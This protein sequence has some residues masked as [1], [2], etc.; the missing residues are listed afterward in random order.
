VALSATLPAPESTAARYFPVDQVMQIAGQRL[1]DAELISISLDT[2]NALVDYLFTF[3]A[4]GW[5]KALMF[6]NSRAEVE[7]YAAAIRQRSPFGD[8]VYVH[9]S[10]IA[11]QRRREIEQQF[12]STDVALCCAT[13]T[14]ARLCTKGSR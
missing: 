1:L 2:A 8:A 11:P 6:C 14:S 13:S 7:T 3:R 5:R 12:A 9:Y 4:K 10:N